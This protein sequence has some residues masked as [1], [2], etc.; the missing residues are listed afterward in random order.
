MEIAQKMPSGPLRPTK[1]FYTYG[2]M[3]F[4]VRVRNGDPNIQQ[5]YEVC[6]ILKGLPQDGRR[7]SVYLLIRSIH[8]YHFKSDQTHWTVALKTF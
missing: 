5:L 4:H 1:F 6:E 3:N 8:I 7:I 2:A